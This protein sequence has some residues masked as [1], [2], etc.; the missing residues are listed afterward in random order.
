MYQYTDFDKQFVAKRAAQYRDQLERNLAGGTLSD[1]EFRPCACKT[2]GMSSATPPCCAWPCPT[3]S[4]PAPS[5]ACWPRIARD[6]DRPSP[7]LLAEAQ[8]TQDRWATGPTPGR[9]LKAYGH[10]TTR[11]N[12]QFNWIPLDKSADVMDLLA[13]VN[14]HGIQTSGNCIRN[15]TSDERAGIAVD[16]D[17]RPAPV[18]RNPAPVEHAAP[19]VR[20]FAA[21]V[22]DRHHRRARRPRRHRLAR[23]GPAPA[24]QRRGRTGL[25]GAGGRWH[26]PHAGHWHTIREFLPWNQIINYLEA[27]VRV[28]NR[29]GRRDNMYK[30]RIKILVKAEGQRYIDEVEPN[31]ARSWKKTAHRTPSP[32]PSWTAWR[33][34]CAARAAMRPQD[35]DAKIAHILRAA[36]ED[37]VEFGRWLQ[38]NV[39]PTRTPTCA[40]SRCRSSAWAKRPATPPPTSWTAP[41]TWPTSSAPARPA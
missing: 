33:Q 22:Q 16:E 18:C 10:F 32:R 6:Y 11:Q 8:A 4:S 12:V 21:Q 34:L 13:S 29:W 41:P 38:Q 2:A 5:C 35:A 25:Q 3:A 19:R 31:T 26:G 14:M 20:L 37:D 7:E 15:I 30:A 40:P 28:Y 1:D 27:V 24:A 9:Q 23:R 17:R 36:A 39:A